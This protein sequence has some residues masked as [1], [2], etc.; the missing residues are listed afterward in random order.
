MTYLS[1][2]RKN[3]AICCNLLA[4]EAGVAASSVGKYI[5]GDP[6]FFDSCQRVDIRTG[7]YDYV[8]GRFSAIWPDHL[9]WP[10]GVD[11]P[12]P[13]PVEP[14]TLDW[15]LPRLAPRDRSKDHLPADWPKDK[16]WPHDIA[17]P[18]KTNG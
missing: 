10:E 2:F 5:A 13:S 12:A 15:F 18:E 16:P 9:P 1:L 17:I 4:A 3:L 11:R 7:T 6:K 8:M 14:Q